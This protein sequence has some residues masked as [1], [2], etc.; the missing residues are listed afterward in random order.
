MNANLAFPGI[1][2]RGNPVSLPQVVAVGSHL[3]ASRSGHYASGRGTVEIRAG[4]VYLYATANGLDI[5]SD[6]MF[7]P[8][9]A[10]HFTGFNPVTRA[11]THLDVAGGGHPLAG[12]HA[13]RREAH[14]GTPRTRQVNGS[15]GN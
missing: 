9:G 11:V 3:L 10:D 13:D 12:L 4:S 1:I 2:F 8:Q 7:F 15:R 6:V 14:S 5:P